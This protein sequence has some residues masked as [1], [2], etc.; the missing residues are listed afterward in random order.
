M[1]AVRATPA[2]IV[3]RRISPPPGASQ[4]LIVRETAP[5]SGETP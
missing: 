1:E 4:T 3:V 5:K 2:A